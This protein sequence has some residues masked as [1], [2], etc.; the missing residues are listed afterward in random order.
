MPRSLICG[1][2]G[3]SMNDGIVTC[4]YTDIIRGLPVHVPPTGRR[5]ARLQRPTGPGY[6]SLYYFLGAFQVLL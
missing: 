2:A 4:H 5:T 6:S 1:L 3:Y